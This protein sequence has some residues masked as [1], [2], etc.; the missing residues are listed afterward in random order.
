MEHPTIIH[1]LKQL[2]QSKGWK[3]YLDLSATWRDKQEAV[4]ADFLR[5]GRLEEAQ[6]VQG[7]LD[8]V[9]SMFRELDNYIMYLAEASDKNDPQYSEEM[10]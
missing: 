3:I 7:K 5:R 10:P 9:N 2:V 8:G 6:Y 4:K 1:N